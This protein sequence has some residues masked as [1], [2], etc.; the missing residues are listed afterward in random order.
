ML[1]A[2][3]DSLL[4]LGVGLLNIFVAIVLAGIR[5]RSENRT[6]PSRIPDDLEAIG[7]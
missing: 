1:A 4:L 5:A 6:A 2:T 3:P 7:G